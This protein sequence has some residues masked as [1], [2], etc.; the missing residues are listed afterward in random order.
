MSDAFVKKTE[1]QANGADPSA[2]EN[3]L[4][5]SEQMYRTLFESIDEGFCLVDLIRDGSGEPIDMRYVEVNG[6]FERQTG[7]TDALGKTHTDLGLKTEPHWFEK[8]D[9]V[10]L[11][12]VSTRFESYHEPTQRWYNVFVSPTGGEGCDRLA[13]VFD[14]FTERKHSEQLKTFLLA[15]SDALRPVSDPRLIKATATRLLGEYLA[16]NRAFYAEAENGNWIV[17]RGFE[18]GVSPLPDVPFPMDSYGPWI[19]EDFRAGRPLVVRDVGT[20]ERYLPEEREANVALQISAAVAI[21]LVKGGSLVAMLCLH[22][23]TPRDWSDHELELLHETAERTWAAVERAKAE[24]GLRDSEN[25]FRTLF[26]SMDDGFCSIEVLFDEAGEAVDYKFLIVNSAFARET[27]FENVVGKT[28]SELVPDPDDFWL[29][30]YGDIARS[31][32]P[33]RF[34]H[35]A[36]RLGKYFDVYAF[37][38]GEP[39]KNEVAVIFN[40]I[41]ERKHAEAALAL[42]EENRK[43]ALEAANLGTFVWYPDED[44]AVP[45]ERM[46]QLFG[47]PRDGMLNLAKAME[48]MFP[49]DERDAYGAAI[50]QALASDGSLVLDIRVI[51]PDGSIK[52]VAINAQ[53]VFEGESRRP[54]KMYGVASDIT[55]KILHAEELKRANEKLEEKVEERTAELENANRDLKNEVK[56]RLEVEKHRSELLRR[57]VTTQEDERR[58]IAR[59][60]H[61][62]L[63]QRL[64]ALR[65][66]LASL[67]ESCEG[68]ELLKRINRLQE[69]GEVID[70]EVSFLSWQLRPTVLDDLGLVTAAGN[71]VQ[72][73][74]A[75]CDIRADFGEAGLSK[76]R[77]D[78][79]AESNLYRILQEALNN[80]AK[81][82]NASQVNV[83]LEGRKN[84]VVLIIEDDGKGFDPSGAMQVTREK[85]LG[86]LGIKERAAIVGG[87]VQIES[88]PGSGTTVFVTIPF[89]PNRL[90]AR[91]SDQN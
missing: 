34:Q 89:A 78:S 37:P 7:L 40:D 72:E 10:A 42:S 50:E 30:T 90:E 84:D 75:H 64:T 23:A 43:L 57:I 22:S 9:Q 63:G 13:L 54:V 76:R 24:S 19:I 46:L 67:K 38:T 26:E 85:G 80:I 47:L 48:T 33:A 69:I 1:S 73:W 41:Y 21:P 65:L 25:R 16:V 11:T 52:W 18:K 4:R 82:A 27:G 17:E 58:R 5:E 14:D 6:V 87:T 74:A 36:P 68:E 53:T 28:A 88:E 60:L 77:L 51:Q 44:R 61:D 8:Y 86:L 12:S 81:H 91:K 39:G 32:K 2:F 66:K 45:N 59:D 55:E 15:L 62:T 29:K 35:P 49:A 70:K 31:G 56:E 83:L 3:A 20:E 79:I 71:Y